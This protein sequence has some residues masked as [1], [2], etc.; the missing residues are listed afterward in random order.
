MRIL[1]RFII[2]LCFL[3]WG[4]YTHAYQ[5]HLY[6]TL[7]ER[8]E[9]PVPASSTVEHDGRVRVSKNYPANTRNNAGDAVEATEIE[10][11]DDDP[12]SFKKRSPGGN[13]SISFF[14]GEEAGD[15]LL[16]LH[17]PLPVCEHFSYHSSNKF[18]LHRVI[19]I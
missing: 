7:K 17:A 11:E 12:T 8:F 18:I 14:D 5:Q 13:G 3:L 9:R 16:Y 19:R 2:S 10:E 15:R 6:N 4:G 1:I